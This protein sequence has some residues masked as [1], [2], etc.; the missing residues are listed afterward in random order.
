MPKLMDPVREYWKEIQHMEKTLVDLPSMSHRSRG[1]KRELR[2]VWEELAEPLRLRYGVPEWK[3]I[4]LAVRYLYGDDS[5][6]IHS[7][8]PAA[9]EAYGQVL[10]EEIWIPAG[11]AKLLS[12]MALEGI[13]MLPQQ[14]HLS[15]QQ[16]KQFYMKFMRSF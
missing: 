16:I 8:F 11:D 2:Y 5:V 9:L 14:E 15:W 6:E 10:E 7:I 3:G 13:E 12:A 4:L 1:E